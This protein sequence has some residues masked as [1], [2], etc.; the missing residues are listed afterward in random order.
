VL[1]RLIFSRFNQ[2]VL[3]GRLKAILSGGAVLPED[4]QLFAKA[5]LCVRVFQGYGLT[6]TCA[7]GTIADRKRS[8]IES[9]D[10]FHFCSEYDLTTERAG[11]PLVSCE[12]RLI[13]WQEGHYKTT[14]KPNPRGEVLIGGKVVADSYFGEAAEENNV[15]FEEINGTRYFHT[16]DIGEVFP[17]GT[18]KIIG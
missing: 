8:L 11:H 9:I 2:M 14:D 5:V 10:L 18:L 17:D 3:G 1:Y 6:E 7:A 4:T 12:I 16:G 13:D 15:N